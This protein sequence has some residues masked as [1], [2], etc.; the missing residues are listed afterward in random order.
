MVEKMNV[1]KKSF[2]NFLVK[3]YRVN[4]KTM[5]FPLSHR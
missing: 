5:S 1:I 4:K 2:L 3:R